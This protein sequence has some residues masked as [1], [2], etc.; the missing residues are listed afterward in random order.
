MSEA[1]ISLPALGK[2]EW[3]L[4]WLVLVCAFIALGYGFYLVLRVIREDPG[5][6]KMQEVSQAIQE[7]AMAY[8]G[9]QFKTMIWFVHAAFFLLLYCSE[10]EKL[11]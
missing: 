2:T 11:R 8:L 10:E 6:P 4:L 9:R 1:A 5:S 7:G 3:Q